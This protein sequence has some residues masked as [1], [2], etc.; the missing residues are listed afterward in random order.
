MYGHKAYECRSKTNWSSNKKTKVNHNGNSYNWD[1]NTR[2]RCHY[3]Q[4]CG[5]VTENCIRTHFSSDYKIW[6]SQNT[7]FSCLKIGHIRKN[8]PPRSKAPSSEF[9]KGKGNIYVEEG[10]MQ[11]KKSWKKEAYSTSSSDGITSSNGSTDH[12]M[13]N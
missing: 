9:S 6:L 13:L 3:C 7:C 11:M 10:L 12:T 2:Y 5:H 8:Y 1:C 4:E